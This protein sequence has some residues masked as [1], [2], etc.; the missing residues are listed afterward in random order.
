M[1]TRWTLDQLLG[2]F[3]LGQRRK[4]L[5]PPI[6]DPVHQLENELFEIW[7]PGDPPRII[8]RPL[9]LRLGRV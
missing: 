7:R 3:E 2:I 6:L 5:L 9:S 8:V 1:E 4:N